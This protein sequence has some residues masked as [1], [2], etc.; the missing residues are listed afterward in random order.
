MSF[1][2]AR[3]AL[4]TESHFGSRHAP[5]RTC[6][7]CR[8]SFAQT[9]LVRLNLR[10]GEIVIVAKPG[11]SRGRSVYIC[12]SEKC[13]DSAFRRGALVFSR[14]KH[15][16]IVVRVTDTERFILRNKFIAFMK[17]RWSQ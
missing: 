4:E 3:F 10:N 5:I 8:E 2:E 15:N 13:F 16:R 11:D 9:E 17:S 14:S 7:G 1:G 12:P 6:V